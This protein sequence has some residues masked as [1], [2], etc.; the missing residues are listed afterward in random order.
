MKSR[1]V[2]VTGGARS[3]KSSFAEEHVLQLGERIGY[4]ATAEP[5][6]EGMQDRIKKHISQRPATW[7]TY[8]CYQEISPE[9]QTIST[10]CD[11]VIL[12]CITV[13]LTN[14]MFKNEMD[15]ETLSRSRI[16]EIEQYILE[17]VT[18]LIENMRE[19]HLNAVIVTN[20]VG[21]GIVPEN[22][23]SRVFRDMAG[24]VNQLISKQSDDVYYV[25]SGIPIKI[26]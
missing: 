24:R 15:W 11:V 21:A 1:I 23:L 8:E 19:H 22:R 13:M 25:V 26:K 6:D 3:G 5:F 2:L 20:E 16:D 17:E 18:Q 4:I 14:L 10:S 9:I 7:P 12:D